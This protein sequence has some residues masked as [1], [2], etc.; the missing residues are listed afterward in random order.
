MST[1]REPQPGK[2]L[3][4]VL[5]EES[6]WDAG[7]GG[8]WLPLHEELVR[9][10]GPVDYKSGLLPFDHTGYYEEELGRPLFR[11]ILGFER[12]LPLDGLPG[13]K[14]ATNALEKAHA[15]PSGSRRVNLD[16]GVLTLE[17]LVLASGKN[18]THRVYLGQ[19]IWADLTLIYSKR[20]GWVTLPWT[21]PDYATEDMQRRLTALRS[22]YKTAIEGS[23]TADGQN[24]RP[25]Q[26]DTP[27][28]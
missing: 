3:L 20:E 11:R 9:R 22:L 18:F 23:A 2:A 24:S 6:W 8:G 14:L 13:M 16:P 7:A 21:F 28:P 12:L 25:E 5:A 15:R 19:G 10:F 17:R 27:C 1:P 26:G 4:S